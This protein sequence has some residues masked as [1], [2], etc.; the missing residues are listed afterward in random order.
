MAVALAEYKPMLLVDV[1]LDG[2][3]QR[4][5]SRDFYDDSGNFYKGTLQEIPGITKALSDL[6]YGVE[7]TS[8][9]TLMIANPESGIDSTWDEI[10]VTDGDE[11]RERSVLIQ[12]NDPLDGTSF[13]LRGKITE[14]K[15]G[16][17]VEITV[18]TRRDYALETLLP[19]ALVTNDA[20]WTATAIDIGKPVNL[21]FGYCRNVPLRNINNDRG[22]DFYDYLIGYGAI[23]DLWIDHVNGI[24]VKRDGVLVNTAEYGANA[25]DYN[26]G[27][28]STVLYA[29]YAV[30]RFKREQM[31]FTGAFHQLTADVKGLKLGGGTAERNFAT[32][33]KNILSD[34]TWGLGESVDVASFVTAAAAL[35]TAS[36]MCDGAITSQTKSRDVLNSLLFPSRAI[37]TRATD[38]EW[39]MGPSG[40]VGQD[41]ASCNILCTWQ[42][43]NPDTLY[44]TLPS[45]SHEP[46]WR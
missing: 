2:G 9:V 6:Y 26:D 22:N 35:P 13:E 25:P 1:I 44:H 30:I 40:A 37:L 5:A 14:Y 24:G 34:G 23:E 39:E 33:I 17:T 28:V 19:Q 7:E 41:A 31:S 32:V 29:G 15:L 12:R 10:I 21:C 42:I 45:G 16:P 4:V 18:E 8:S 43:R 27:K 36:Y 20:P 46:P 11:P 3:T 38:G